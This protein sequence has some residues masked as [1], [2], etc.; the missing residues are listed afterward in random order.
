MICT[1]YNVRKFACDA[2]GASYA[3]DSCSHFPLFCSG[4]KQ[5]PRPLGLLAPRGQNQLE[6]RFAYP[7][8]EHMGE[9]EVPELLESAGLALLTPMQTLVTCAQAS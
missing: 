5:T 6:E 3:P 4:D 2:R 8:T 1:P 9:R 7:I